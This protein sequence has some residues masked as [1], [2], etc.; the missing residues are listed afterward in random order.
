VGKEKIILLNFTENTLFT[1][2]IFISSLFSPQNRDKRYHS[3]GV[4]IWIKWGYLVR[5]LQCAHLF[6][7]IPKSPCLWFDLLTCFWRHF[8]CIALPQGS[9]R[10]DTDPLPRCV[11][12]RQRDIPKSLLP[13]DNEP[14][15]RLHW[16]WL[17][18]FAFCLFF[19]LVARLKMA[20]GV[21]LKP[22]LFP[23]GHFF[24]AAPL[25]LL[26][27][28]QTL[29]GR[30]VGAGSCLEFILAWY[31]WTR[32]MKSMPDSPSSRIGWGLSADMTRRCRFRSVSEMGLR[33]STKGVSLLGH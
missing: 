22:K 11:D 26:Q 6:G 28:P 27:D 8:K 9:T 21:W 33:V 31:A 10:L 16:L 24:V 2:F 4:W 18:S 17:A 30:V 7:N 14:W 20:E 29:E 19:A 12:L 5:Q 15:Q 32:D 1:L 25:V 3:R 23:H 13:L